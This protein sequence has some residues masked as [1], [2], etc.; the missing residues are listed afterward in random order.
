MYARCV[1]EAPT[2]LDELARVSQ[3][4]ADGEL[5]WLFQ[6]P[7][8]KKHMSRATSGRSRTK[9]AKA[10]RRF[11]KTIDVVV[12]RRSVGLRARTPTS[13]SPCQEHW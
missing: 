5:I 6:K 8:T 13:G 9:K 3:S 7:T 12:P 2:P 10:D 1:A 11:L 4:Q